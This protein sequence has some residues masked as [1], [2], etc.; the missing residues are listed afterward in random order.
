[1]VSHS[2]KM[3]LLSTHSENEHL[4]NA[5]Y[6]AVLERCGS[7]GKFVCNIL[8]NSGFVWITSWKLNLSPRLIHHKITILSQTHHAKSNGL[9]HHVS[10]PR[11]PVRRRSGGWCGV[12][13]SRV[14]HANRAQSAP[15]G[16]P[17][18]RSHLLAQLRR[19]KQ[20]PRLPP[21]L[22]G[23]IHHYHTKL[24]AQW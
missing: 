10:T 22:R 2:I 4:T 7:F 18:H 9:L 14:A 12:L 8:W 24:T 17:S 16:G 1:M 20:S 13:E 21:G 5:F 6:H 11:R 19:W 23:V 3:V 15:T